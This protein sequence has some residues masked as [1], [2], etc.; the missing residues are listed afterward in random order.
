MLA[1]KH[2]LMSPFPAV[3]NPLASPEGENTPFSLSTCLDLE[4]KLHKTIS[5]I[6]MVNNSN[7][8]SLQKA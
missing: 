3:Q 7:I 5:S 4:K 6:Q 8:L 1:I 2:S